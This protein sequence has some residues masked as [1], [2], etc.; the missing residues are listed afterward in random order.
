MDEF[1][2]LISLLDNTQNLMILAFIGCIVLFLFEGYKFYRYKMK[3]D[4][5]DF[6]LLGAIGLG[7]FILFDDLFLSVIAV[8]FV[9]MVIGTYELRESPVWLRLMAAFTITY[10]YL[11]IGT[12]FEKG[13]RLLVTRNI[14][15]LP[16]SLSWLL[17]SNR[18]AGFFWSTM[19]WI[20]LISS[21]VFFGKRFILVSRFLSPQYVYL[22]VY[23]AVY[24]IVLGTRSIPWEYRYLVLFISNLFLYSISGPMLSFLFQIKP[25]DDERALRIIKEVEAKIG[26]KIRSIGIVQAPILNAF[27]YGPFFDQKFAFI[28]KDINN[29]T[30]EELLGITA[31]EISHLKGKH[32]FWLLWIGFVDLA[33]RLILNIPA[34][35]L[36]FV[37]GAQDNRPVID[38]FTYYMVNMVFFAVSLIF[39]RIMEANADKRTKEIGYGH[40]LGAAL[41]TLEGFYRGIA[42]E[43]GLNATLLTDST[44]TEAE[45]KRFS[46]EAA[47]EM[48]N[49]LMNPSRYGLVMNLIVSHPPTPFRIAAMVSDDIGSVRLALLPLLLIIPGTRSRNIKLLRRSESDF[50]ELLTINYNKRFTSVDEYI[51]STFAAE[52]LMHYLNRKLLLISKLNKNQFYIGT[53][54]ATISSTNIVDPLALELETDNK[55]VLVN[56]KNFSI[57]VYEPES[58]Y[59]VKKKELLTL[60]SAEQ[61]KSGKLV[62]LYEK[63]S[64]EIKLNYLGVN[65]KDFLIENSFILQ[66]RGTYEPL[67]LQT[68]DN[69]ETTSNTISSL[70][71]LNGVSF[72]FLS[73]NPGKEVNII[74]NEMKINLSPIVLFLY[75]RFENENMALI[76]F[77]IKTKTK[78]VMYTSKDP[79]IGIPCELTNIT[80]D[81]KVYYRG[82]G[83]IKED[84]LGLRQVDALV[85]RY[86]FK[87]IQSTAEIGIFSKLFD[88]ILSKSSKLQNV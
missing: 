41:Y 10:G 66:S 13:L 80:E 83:E 48:H 24:L 54:K 84:F 42:G 50:A 2:D 26:T 6:S 37:F 64:K 36:D 63:N 27:A 35:Q 53:L 25:L 1:N 5:M 17:D 59:I 73:F 8:I 30:D 15:L 74:G 69:K 77:L 85:L 56:S 57:Q 43:L 76:R 4:L 28:V 38:L 9:L 20:L 47:I 62:Y 72:N 55:N 14:L 88:K 86:P 7:S 31:H 40:E 82:C 65:F 51:H 39:V 70:K 79:D 78:I 58:T 71:G 60:K 3:S 87:L 52:T 11:L 16:E 44:R 68:I 21:F 18:I 19:M 45:E 61:T 29:F 32:T 75:K 23:S 46:G 33:I 22:F 81:K 12:L 67:T 34:T 49:K